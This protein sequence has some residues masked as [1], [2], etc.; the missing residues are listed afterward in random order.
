MGN[1]LRKATTSGSA[2]LTNRERKY[3]RQTWQAFCQA[4]QDYGVLIFV[5]FFQRYPSYLPLF[6]PFGDLPLKDLVCNHRFRAHGY[7]VG[8]QIAAVLD[9]LDDLDVMTELVRKTAVNHA[10]KP[11]LKPEHFEHLLHVILETMQTR[12]PEQFT[13]DVIA[14]WIKLFDGHIVSSSAVYLARSEC[15]P[16]TPLRASHS[17]PLPL[18]LS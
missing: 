5:E 18:E 13:Q 1:S 7:A 9:T 4:N 15:V 11:G 16:S 14:A 8:H 10:A 17:S 6:P 12:C 2:N 3:V